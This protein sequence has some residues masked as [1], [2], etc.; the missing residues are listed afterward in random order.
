MSTQISL[1]NRINRVVTDKRVK[2]RARTNGRVKT[3]R[4]ITQK[5]VFFSRN[6][7]SM[8]YFVR[9]VTTGFA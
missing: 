3:N 4:I 5:S 6:V 2:K 1:N 8:Q 7:S 9:F